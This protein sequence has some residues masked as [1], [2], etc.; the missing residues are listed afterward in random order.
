M[1]GSGSGAGGIIGI[2]AAIVV[3]VGG[4]IAVH[5]LLPSLFHIFMWGIAGLAVLV[6]ATFVLVIFFANKSSNEKKEGS[7]A[8]EPEKLDN[9]QD[10]ILKDA[11]ANLMELRRTVS[12]IHVMDIRTRANDVCQTLDRIL[13][14]LKEKPERIRASRQCLNYYIPTLIQVLG[15][16]GELD[17]KDQITE[18]IRKKTGSFLDDVQKALKSYYN[19]LFEDDRID[20]E[21]DMEAMTIAIKRDGLLEDR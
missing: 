5:R 18:D 2:L 13:L 4:L 11:R 3:S 21:V 20:M 19:N 1:K 12:K 16:Y 15:H 7:D 14:T 6:I 17:F 8:A 10:E 9:E